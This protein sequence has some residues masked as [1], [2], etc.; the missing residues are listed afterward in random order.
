MENKVQSQEFC[1]SCLFIYILWDDARCTQSQ[2]DFTGSLVKSNP[3]KIS[4]ALNRNSHSTIYCR[5]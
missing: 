5:E 3:Y 4:G 1:A 2:I